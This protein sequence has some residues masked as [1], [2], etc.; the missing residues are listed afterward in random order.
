MQF[1]GDAKCVGEPFD[2]IEPYFNPLADSRAQYT[3]I[4]S[5]DDYLTII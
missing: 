4:G 1:D 3:T 5:T 2:T